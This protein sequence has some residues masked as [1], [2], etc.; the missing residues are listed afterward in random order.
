MCNTISNASVRGLWYCHCTK[1]Q[2]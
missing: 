2:S 1:V